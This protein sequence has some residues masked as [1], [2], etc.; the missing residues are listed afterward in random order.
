M[1]TILVLGATGMLGR[2]TAQRLVDDGFAV[3]VLARDP[4]AARSRLGTAVEVVAGDVTDE[5]RLE[6]A[7]SGCDGV[8]ISISGPAELPAATGV[9]ELA[10]KLGLERITYLSGSTVS[11][12]NGD[13]PMVAAKLDA[14]R[15]IVGSGVGY[16]IF[17]PTW[18]M[19]QLP[20]F[21][22][23]PSALVI[24]DRLPA[25]HWFAADDL[26]RMVARAFA[27]PEAAN[28]R[29]FV[30][31]PEALTMP[32]AVRRYCDAAG[33]EDIPVTVLPIAEARA[34]AQASG[35]EMLA[36]MA[37]TMAYF[38]AAGELGDPSEADDLLGAPTTSLAAWAAARTAQ[39]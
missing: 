17:C 21:V 3:R 37:Q 4:A 26:G 19:E 27:T 33:L 23:G 15:A 6:Q 24:G 36:Y 18:P 35:N 20:R 25:L 14:E 39:G 30:H 12:A 9:A 28:R 31:G 8:H 5:A 13:F 32:Q 38:D 16:T 22:Q 29:L 7:I 34:Q 10:G 2:P 1:H 11:E